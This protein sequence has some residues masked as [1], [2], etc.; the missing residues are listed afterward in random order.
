MKEIN[1]FINNC[2]ITEGVG[3]FGNCTM[4][5][6]LNSDTQGNMTLDDLLISYTN[7]WI[8]NIYDEMTG[9]PFIMTDVNETLLTFYCEDETHS[10]DMPNNVLENISIGCT[11]DYVKLAMTFGSPFSDTSSRLPCIH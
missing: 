11:V 2:T 8:V 3:I 6:F 9:E 7:D 1:D 5:V 4:P 10:F